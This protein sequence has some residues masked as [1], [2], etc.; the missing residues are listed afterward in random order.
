MYCKDNALIYSNYRFSNL[1]ISIA[2]LARPAIIFGGTHRCFAIDTMCMIGCQGR[3]TFSKLNY[4]YFYLFLFKC[5]QVKLIQ[6]M[7]RITY[8]NTMGIEC[9]P[10]LTGYF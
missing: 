8:P 5:L 2:K 3:I 10:L 9:L 1:S 6:I 7:Y 4:E